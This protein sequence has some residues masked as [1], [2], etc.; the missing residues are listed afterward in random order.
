MSTLGSRSFHKTALGKSRL[1]E[2]VAHGKRHLGMMKKDGKKDPVVKGLETLMNRSELKG[3]VDHTERSKALGDDMVKKMASLESA[4]G[5]G[6][7][8]VL[9]M[10]GERA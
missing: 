3:I 7:A 5:K 2:A 10:I 9:K 1:F 8:E 6:A 4:T